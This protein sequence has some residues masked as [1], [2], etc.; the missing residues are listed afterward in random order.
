MLSDQLSEKGFHILRFDYRGTGNSALDL[1]QISADEWL[2]DI[3]EAISELRDISGVKKVSLLGLRLGALLATKV[4]SNAELP[5][6]R[7]ITWDAV[8][9]GQDYL[10][11]MI[12]HSEQ[13]SLEPPLHLNGFCME[14]RFIERL[15]P[16]ALQ[17]MLGSLN[18][19][20]L[21]CVSHDSENYRAIEEKLEPNPKHHFLKTPAPYDWNYIDNVGGIL[22]PLP[23]MH[24]IVD[25]LE[26][27]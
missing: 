15:K 19:T 18:T 14:S 11:E 21:F 23:I 17:P 2:E 3:N 13:Q 24:A 22:L 20:I 8:M 6:Q 26:R 5:I 16:M 7:L 10:N 27:H 4:A 25:W 1:E 12:N 9:G